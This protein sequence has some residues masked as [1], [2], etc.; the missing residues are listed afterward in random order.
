MNS[1]YKDW[2]ACQEAMA[3]LFREQ[4]CTAR[5]NAQIKSARGTHSIDVYLKF[6]LQGIECCWIIKCKLWKKYVEKANVMTLKAIIEN[7]GAD[8][9]IIFCENGFQSGALDAIPDGFPMRYTLARAGILSLS[10][11]RF[12]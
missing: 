4:G 9:G 8:R 6:R 2:R 1:I 10:F 7:V 11:T 5:V 12:K 3:V